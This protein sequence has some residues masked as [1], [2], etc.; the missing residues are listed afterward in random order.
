M[1][2]VWSAA[3]KIWIVFHRA[4]GWKTNTE[5]QLPLCLLHLSQV[6]HWC[7]HHSQSPWILNFQLCL[8]CQ[9]SEHGVLYSTS[10]PWVYLQFHLEN[11]HTLTSGRQRIKMIPENHQILHKCVL[12]NCTQADRM[13]SAMES[14]L[15]TLTQRQMQLTWLADKKA[16][17]IP[18]HRCVSIQE[19]TGKFHHHW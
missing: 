14:N 12:N 11:I 10:G 13:Q 16:H 19:V 9:L 4:E 15:R 17:V 6:L 7:A 2:S 8:W 5:Q 1:I 3:I 18:E